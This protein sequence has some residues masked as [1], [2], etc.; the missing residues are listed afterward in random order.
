MMNIRVSA[1]RKIKSAVFSY[2]ALTCSFKVLIDKN[3]KKLQTISNK[4][5]IPV[6]SSISVAS[7]YFEILREV[8]TIKQN[9]NR[10]EEVFKICGDLLFSI[11][12]IIYFANGGLFFVVTIYFEPQI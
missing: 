1:M 6:H 5:A 4:A 9:P 12:L 7:L 10:L 3:D 2:R 8:N 11:K